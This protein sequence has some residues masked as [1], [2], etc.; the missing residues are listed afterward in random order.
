MARSR[1]VLATA[2]I[3]A[4]VAL[5]GCS[6]IKVKQR[7]G[8]AWSRPNPLVLVCDPAPTPACAASASASELRRFVTPIIDR[9]DERHIRTLTGPHYTAML[10]QKADVPRDALETRTFTGEEYAAWVQRMRDAGVTVPH[11]RITI[12]VTEF[13]DTE[14]YVPAKTTYRTV[15]VEKKTT[16]TVRNR[17]KRDEDVEKVVKETK[18]IPEYHEAY[19]QDMGMAGVVVK[20]FDEQ[21]LRQALIEFGGEGFVCVRPVWTATDQREEN[22][23]SREEVLTRIMEKVA[24]KLPFKDPTKAK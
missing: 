4:C 22:D 5:T 15:E 20:V 19:Y 21:E 6:T 14:E 7:E 2:A 18:L 1:G 17:H 24:K 23:R 10:T 8:Y 11:F 9:L 3:L 13:E 12:D 16:E